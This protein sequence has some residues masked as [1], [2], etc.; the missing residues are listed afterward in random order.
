MYYIAACHV[1]E[2]QLKLTGI[3]PCDAYCFNY[4]GTQNLLGVHINDQG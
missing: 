3:T 1:S 2:Y 4:W